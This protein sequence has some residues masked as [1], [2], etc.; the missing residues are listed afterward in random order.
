MHIAEHLPRD[1]LLCII[2]NSHTLHSNFRSTSTSVQQ[3]YPIIPT[4]AQIDQSD[5]D[6]IA[7]ELGKVEGGDDENSIQAAHFAANPRS[8][9]AK[10][11]QDLDDKTDGKKD[12]YD[13]VPIDINEYLLKFLSLM[14]FVKLLFSEGIR[15][16][17]IK[18]I[19]S[20]PFYEKAE[21]IRARGSI[22]IPTMEEVQI[23]AFVLPWAPVVSLLRSSHVARCRWT[24]RMALKE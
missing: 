16:D 22:L 23:T 15:I 4:A 20:R 9:T 18:S 7:A 14:G 12:I 1:L 10:H 19:S 5:F 17:A 2:N 8:G 6:H 11:Q 24:K 21:L 13:Y 3:A